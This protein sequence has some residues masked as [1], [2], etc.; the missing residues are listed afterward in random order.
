MQNLLKYRKVASNRMLIDS[1]AHLDMEEFEGDLPEVLARALESGVSEIISIGIDL[2]SSAKALELARKHD[3]VYST[4]GYHPHNAKEAD[5]KV[6]RDLADLALDPKVVA[7]GEIGL[8]FFRRHSPPQSQIEAFERQLD[9]AR[10]L[11]LPVIVHDREAHEQLSEIL[12]KK[13]PPLTGVIHCF[14]GDYALARFFMDMGFYISIPGTVTYKKAA[15]VQEVAAR[16]PL[17]RLLVETDAPYLAPVPHRG[18]RNEPAFVK[19][20]AQE[21][22]RLRGMDY[23]ELARATSENARTLFKLGNR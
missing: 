10:D 3:F 1:H 22:A 5:A 8:D 15:L 16:I 14:S 9:M 23:Q 7:W 17:E 19:Y 11:G 13:G 18:K 12:R 6:L 2:P 4:V 20:T 21:I